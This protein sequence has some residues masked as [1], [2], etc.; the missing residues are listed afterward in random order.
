[1]PATTPR[2][3]ENQDCFADKSKHPYVSAVFVKNLRAFSVDAGLQN[4]NFGFQIK[5]EAFS[6]VSKG[7]ESIFFFRI[8]PG[9]RAGLPALFKV[10]T[11]DKRL[12]AAAY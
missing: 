5:I 3:D 8:T 9:G 10:A 12:H 1:M 2:S 4:E 11:A 7:R 6:Q